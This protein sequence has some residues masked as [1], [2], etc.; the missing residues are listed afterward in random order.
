[1]CIICIIICIILSEVCT[2]SS[3]FGG[4]EGRRNQIRERKRLGQ[5]RTT[6]GHTEGWV[7]CNVETDD[8]KLMSISK[9]CAIS[10]SIIASCFLDYNRISSTK[11]SE[12]ILCLQRG[13]SK[14]RSVEPICLSVL[15][16]VRPCSSRRLVSMPLK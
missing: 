3:Y 9:S 1:M 12:C 15:D 10:H 13:D 11:R 8:L 14:D 5:G 4:R 16:F 6:H 7:K 2:C